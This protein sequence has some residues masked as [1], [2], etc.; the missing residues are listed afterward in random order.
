MSGEDGFTL[1]EAMVALL[2][3]S[4]GA[5]G[6]LAATA[7]GKRL[8]VSGERNQV[9]ITYAQ[10]EMERL[11]AL[12]YAE[13]GLSSLPTAE[14]DETPT[15]AAPSTP[16]A[17]LAGCDPAGCTTLRV[18]QDPTNRTS[19]P[20]A[21]VSSAG[22][23]IVTG[24]TQAPTSTVTLDGVSARVYRYVTA[25][26]ERCLARGATEVC[27]P[28]GQVKRITVALVLSG[29][30]RQGVTK[31]VWASTLVTNPDVQALQATS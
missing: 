10:R 8:T 27:P 17:Y 13:L 12:P 16:A 29:Q 5:L 3:L 19:P 11:S 2:M 15:E 31:P 18:L 23:P 21:G 28:A 22:E 24:G 14:T 4:V 9:V 6:V 1:I 26:G 30:R 20:P 7:G 25:V